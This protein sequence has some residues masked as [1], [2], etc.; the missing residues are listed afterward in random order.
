MHDTLDYL[1]HDPDAPQVPPPQPD[2]RLALRVHART[3]CCRLSHDEVVHGKG[4]AHRQD[5]RRP[6]GSS[7]PTCVR[8][9]G[10]MW[11][12][13]GQASCCSWAARSRRT[14]SG[15]TTRSLD[16]H[17]LDRPRAR[18]GPGPG[19]SAQSRAARRAALC[20]SATATPA[21][22][23]WID[24]NDSE[25]Q[26]ATRFVRNSD[27]G[28]QGTS[29]ASA[30]F[31]PVATR[32]VSARRARRRAT[33]PTLLNTE[34]RRGYGGAPAYG[35]SKG[36]RDRP[37]AVAPGTGFERARALISLPPLGRGVVAGST[38]SVTA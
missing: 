10:W 9:Y 8:S 6:A 34:R 18:R 2:V 17:L 24:A 29:H 27:D 4:S 7:S 32:G 23:R 30:N 36:C 13:P 3:S 38:E 16:W 28:R 33:G 1:R 31:T 5:G 25:Q 21:G 37:R 14:A 15:T 12:H 11:A 19:A 22:F 35:K 26:R 20:G